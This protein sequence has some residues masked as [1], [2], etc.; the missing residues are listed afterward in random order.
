MTEEWKSVIGFEGFYDVS[1]LGR[2]KSLCRTVIDANGKPYTVPE[3]IMSGSIKS[4]GYSHV[5]LR[6]TG[7]KQVKR[8]V[9]QLVA[10]AFLPIKAGSSEEVNH[11]DGNKLNN[12]TTNLEWCSHAKNMSHAWS[13]GFFFPRF[14]RSG[15][16]T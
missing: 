12:V 9:H 7:E 4:N 5:S 8:H 6:K 14:K 1:N 16:G 15:N 11:L 13:N 3:R 2:V 10:T